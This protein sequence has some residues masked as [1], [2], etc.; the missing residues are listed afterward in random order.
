N[1]C[2][3]DIVELSFNLDPEI[4]GTFLWSTGST[5]SSIFVSPEF[6]T[7]YYLEIILE[8]E[9]CLKEI[10]IDVKFEVYPPLGDGYQ[11]FCDD[12]P[13]T[14]GDVIV[15]GEDIKW[16]DAPQGGLLLDESELLYSG[17]FLYATQ[18]SDGCESQTRLLVLIDIF[19]ST[20]SETYINS[21]ESLIWNGQTF[22]ESGDY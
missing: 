6:T 18:T 16:Y 3:G 9:T 21:C 12:P 22:N 14:V 15:D 4:N 11:T 2:P 20:S 7:T 10:T 5:S 17:Q 8:E 1:I 13:P 19:E